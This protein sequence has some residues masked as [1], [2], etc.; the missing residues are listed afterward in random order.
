[1]SDTIPDVTVVHTTYTDIYAVTGIVVGTEL[2]LQNKE[3]SEFRVQVTTSQPSADS[4]D[5]VILGPKSMKLIEV[6]SNEVWVIGV[7]SLSVQ[8]P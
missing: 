1:M 8:E 2:I 7:G 4:T 5:G 3:E 6:G